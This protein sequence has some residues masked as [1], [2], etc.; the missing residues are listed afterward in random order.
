MNVQMSP[1]EYRHGV[2]VYQHR[3][4]ISVEPASPQC[5][6]S[7]STMLSILMPCA[8]G[9]DR[10]GRISFPSGVLYRMADVSLFQRFH[11]HVCR[12]IRSG[13]VRFQNTASD[14]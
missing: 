5:G 3:P 8:G 2:V 7:P 1:V 10:V 13:G 11:Q 6:E 4:A 9:D 14:K 12:I